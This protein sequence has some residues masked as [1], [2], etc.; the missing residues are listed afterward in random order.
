MA[1]REIF[2]E[3]GLTQRRQGRK[4]E[5]CDAAFPVCRPGIHAHCGTPSTKPRETRT[6]IYSAGFLAPATRRTMPPTTA[7]TPMIGGSG[8]VC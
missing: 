8:I 4:V 3:E 2:P 7:A 5:P 1:L 6:R